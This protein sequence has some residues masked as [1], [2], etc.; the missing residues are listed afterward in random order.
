MAKIIR[1]PERFSKET[2]SL[3]IIGGG[4]YGVML[5]YEAAAR[6]LKP[7][8]L[9]RDDFG[10]ATTF[11]CLRILH[12]GFRYLQTMD[13]HRFRES[14]SERKWF[15]RA[16]PGLVSPLPCLMP[17]YG[18]GLRRPRIMRM[19][20]LANDF[21]SRD[22]NIGVQGKNILPSS[23]I[24]KID[25]VAALF[26][27]VDTAGLKGG[28]VWYD[29]IM[30]DPQ[31]ILIEI[32]KRSVQSGCAALNYV[33][34]QSLVVEN[35]QVK[36]IMARDRLSSRSYEF[37]SPVVINAA[38]PWCRQFAS[39]LNLDFPELFK[40]SLA[41]NVLFD[42]PALSSH[43]LA[44][45]PKKPNARTYFLVPW[46]GKL[47]AGTG[48]APWNRE[49][50]SPAPPQEV[51]DSFIEDLNTAVPNAGLTRNKILHLFSG[52]LP[53]T[54]EGGIGLTKREVILDHSEN[55]GPNG[56]YSVSG[57]KFTTARLVA[58]KLL[59]KIFA[60]RVRQYDPQSEIFETA[61]NG[62]RAIGDFSAGRIPALDDA[63]IKDLRE[64]IDSEAVV[65]LDD[66]LFR[67]TSL[68]EPT[69]SNEK[70]K[71]QL[72]QH[73]ALPDHPAFGQN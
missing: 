30:S 4:I 55:G 28:L 15:L 18:N 59:K 50:T 72:K 13:L 63:S 32:V 43:A 73:L 70:I 26:P 1:D 38:G 61:G 68:W 34:G 3:I 49:S 62:W 67:R 60:D 47:L 37:E 58:E 65:T 21:L 42:K 27:K 48:H 33:E 20:A 2:Y 22:R 19:A 12:G 8:L 23:R 64:I 39:A 9:E 17:L 41:W 69:P 11:N 52:F 16:F 44:V 56:F 24:L 29:A 53:A 40:A 10:G 31:I 66:L 57:I 46:K 35:N 45:A 71:K 25:Q 54:Q 6:G 7:L 36:G 5:A 51:L 14:V